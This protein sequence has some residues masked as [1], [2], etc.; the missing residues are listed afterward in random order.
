MS[1]PGRGRGRPL[2]GG[3][4]IESGFTAAW[5]CRGPHRQTLWPFLFRLRPRPSYRRERL[6]LRDGDFID[7]DWSG[8]S[9]A[10]TTVVML[11]GLEGSSASHYI[12]ALSRRLAAAGIRSVVMHQRGCSGEPNRLTRFYH[13]GETQDLRRVLAYLRDTLEPVPLYAVGYSLGGNMLLKWLGEAGADAMLEAAVAV[14]VPFRLE[15][16]AKR[17]ERGLSRLYQ[18]HLLRSMKRSVAL[19]KQRMAH[20]VDSRELAACRTF[21][22]I[23]NCLT[24]PLHG[25]RDAR[26]YYE[27]SS[28]RPFLGSIRVPTL[29]LHARDDP[30][31]TPTAVPRAEELA[32]P[33]RLELSKHGGHCGFI[34]DLRLTSALDRYA[35][36]FFVSAC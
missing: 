31:L 13:G 34:E 19:K 29:I 17:L 1:G 16:G 5:W 21:E 15:I 32:S 10:G 24:A 7:L 4:V 14:S 2:H 3:R 20:P 33:V 22:K 11:H 9:E 12:R 36:D 6:E 23:D 18:A 27:R 28:C 35:T 30:F 26:D 25:F 8:P